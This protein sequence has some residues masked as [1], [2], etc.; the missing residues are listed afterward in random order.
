M[1]TKWSGRAT[2][3]AGILAAVVL[4]LAADVSAAGATPPP[5]VF[6]ATAG[7]LFSGVVG[8]FHT[9]NCGLTA[10]ASSTRL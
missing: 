2:W 6:N 4:S 1:R 9:D 3:L 8:G 5:N 7:A 10:A